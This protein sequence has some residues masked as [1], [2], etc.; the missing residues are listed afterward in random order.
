MSL[1]GFPQRRRLVSWHERDTRALP[2]IINHFNS[3]TPENVLKWQS[4]HPQPN[5]YNFD[6]S[7]AYVA[8]GEKYHMFIIGHTL[9]W[10]SHIPSWVFQ[11]EKG[12][13]IDRAGLLERMR[14]HIQTVVGRYKGRIKGWD[15]INEALNEP[16]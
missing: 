4:V 2:I 11:D 9:I 13:P 6:G 14:D 10:H 3:I 5:T 12:N 16:G 15:V 8:F 7:D 1:P